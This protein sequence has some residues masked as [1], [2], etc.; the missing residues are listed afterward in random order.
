MSLASSSLAAL[1]AEM[2]KK[3]AEFEAT[4]HLGSTVAGSSK[5]AQRRANKAKAIPDRPNK[6]LQMRQVKDVD[7]QARS[8][9]TAA[10]SRE[11]L[12]QKA[13]LYD[14]I[15]QVALSLLRGKTAGLTE[16]QIGNLLV[17][18]DQKDS[19]DD[20][21]DA[22]E[23]SSQEGQDPNDPVVEF[24]DEYGRVR[25]AR[26]SEVPRLT[27][28]AE[29]EP[30]EANIRYGDQVY[31]PVYQPDP[32]VIA[33]RRAAFEESAPLVQHYDASKEVRARGAGFMSFSKDE[34]IRQQQMEA[35]K[36]ERDETVRTREHIQT[37]GGAVGEREREIQER[38]RKLEAKRAELEA[39]RK[40]S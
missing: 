21:D 24:T 13:K 38:K 2:A 36:R 12:E 32:A 11:M 6:G 3:E 29:D 1:K 37:S 23:G 33:A 31:F 18:F 25:T 28:Q 34:N 35:L 15:K 30:D 8:T 16:A 10:H 9:N 20:E 17:D 19:D 26:R 5:P 27:A 22:T 4:R 40:R 14:K 39:K 7:D